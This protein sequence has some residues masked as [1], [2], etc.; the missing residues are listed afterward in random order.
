[1]QICS[2]QERAAMPGL[3]DTAEVAR[4]RSTEAS[5]FDPLFLDLI[6]GITRDRSR[7]RILSFAMGAIR[8]YGSWRMRSVINNKAK[9]R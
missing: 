8:A 9:S 1:M 2:S 3:L 7:W 6:P 5:S 4:L